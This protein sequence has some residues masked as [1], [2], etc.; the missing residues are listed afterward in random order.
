MFQASPLTRGSSRDPARTQDD[1]G[2]CDAIGEITNV[3]AI[4][5]GVGLLGACGYKPV[6]N[7][8]VAD[9]IKKFI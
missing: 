1:Y 2:F 7:M 6:I 3:L 9:A 8:A 4:H 5:H